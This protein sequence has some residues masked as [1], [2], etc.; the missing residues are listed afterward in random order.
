MTLVL[1][2]LSNGFRVEAKNTVDSLGIDRYLI[3]SGSAG[4]YIGSSAFAAAELQMVGQIPGIVTAVPLAYAAATVKDGDAIQN[5]NVF[6]APERGPGMPAVTTGRAP[7]GPDEVAVS[8][9]LERAVGNES[10]DRFAQNA[11]RRHRE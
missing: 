4:P 7:S 2:G 10:R 9:A 3:K 6:G 1:T 5:I 8:S 11:N